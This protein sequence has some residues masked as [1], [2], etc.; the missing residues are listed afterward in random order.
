MQLRPIFSSLRHHKLTATLLVLQVAFTLAIVANASFMVV[1]RLQRM[2]TPSGV[3]E[4]ELSMIRVE[5]IGKDDNHQARHLADL[6]ALGRLPGVRSAVAIGPSLPFSGNINSYGACPSQEALERAIA[7][8][9]LDHSG[10]LS[11][12]TYAG[13]PG[14][15]RTLGLQLIAGRDFTAGE[16]VT[17]DVSAVMLTQAAA[18]RLFPGQ[19]ALGRMVYAG[20]QGSR[21]VGIVRDVMRPLLRGDG[22]DHEVMLWPQ[23]PDGDSVTYLLRSAP[24]H[25]GRV[26]AAAAAALQRLDSRRLIPAS[27]QRTFAQLRAH[28][29][30]RDR[31]MVGLLVAAGLGLLFVTVLGISGLANFWVQQ[32]T[33]TIGIRR[34]IGA[35]RVDI[36]RYFQ[37]ENFLIVGGGVLLG[38]LLALALNLLLMSRYELPRLPLA[39]LPVGALALWLLGQLSVLAPAL[40]ASRVP[41]VVATRSV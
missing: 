29:F 3:T 8:S 15:V 1:Q 28:Y 32:R 2:G 4:D 23:L 39:Y 16:Y 17:G 5:G 14:F 13:S 41:P 37:A 7:A 30:Q 31:T 20:K 34:A 27:G 25:R 11:I 26:L 18:R 12:D 40:R 35:T 22:S 9:S 24:Q 10:C 21:V 19:E 6:D 38:M 36:L 33:R